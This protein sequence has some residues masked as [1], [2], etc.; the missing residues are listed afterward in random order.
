MDRDL[1]TSE[2]IKNCPEFRMKVGQGRK[3]GPTEIPS[4]V[5]SVSFPALGRGVMCVCLHFSLFVI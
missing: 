3:H 2:D 4:C 1:L 5:Y